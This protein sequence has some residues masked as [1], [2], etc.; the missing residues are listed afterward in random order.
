M[1]KGEIA[2]YKEFLLSHNVFH[3]YISLLRQTAAL[4]GNGFRYVYGPTSMVFFLQLS[5]LIKFNTNLFVLC[6]LILIYAITKSTLTFS[7]S[8]LQRQRTAENDVE[9]EEKKIWLPVFSPLPAT[10]SSFLKDRF[11]QLRDN[12]SVVCKWFQFE[13]V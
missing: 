11:H 12:L 4:C 10:F 7:Q 2:C 9:K 5:F 8:S 1:G 6:N 3:S 13:Q